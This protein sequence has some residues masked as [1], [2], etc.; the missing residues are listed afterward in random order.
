M[1]VNISNFRIFFC[2]L[3]LLQFGNCGRKNVEKKLPLSNQTNHK[4]G[5]EDKLAEIEFQNKIFDFGTLRDDTIVSARYSFK[6]TGNNPLIIKRVVPDCHCTGYK[7][8]N[9]TIFTG[10]SDTLV[11]NFSTKDKIGPQKI[12][13]IVTANTKIKMY[14]LTLLA[15]VVKR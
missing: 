8:G 13:T 12:Y 2:C 7:L 11:L 3:F 1:K 6:N 9:D 15:N 14:K 10:Q 5:D 4:V